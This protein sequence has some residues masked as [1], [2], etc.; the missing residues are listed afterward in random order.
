MPVAA[1]SSPPLL[2][3]LPTCCCP[4]TSGR[5]RRGSVSEEGVGIAEL[6]V[7]AVL[8]IRSATSTSGASR[9]SVLLQPGRPIFHGNSPVRGEDADQGP[10]PGEDRASFRSLES[11]R[12]V[13]TESLRRLEKSLD[14]V[15]HA[16]LT[17]ATYS[18]LARHLVQHL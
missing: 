8:V 3:P 10:V 5:F 18:M 9:R 6:D 14:R 4:D 11:P 7:T 1:R 15:V 12:G 17:P 2:P 16:Q 13:K